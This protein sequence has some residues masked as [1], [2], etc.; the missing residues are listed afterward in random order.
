MSEFAETFIAWYISVN[1]TQKYRIMSEATI[2]YHLGWIT[3]FSDF[4]RWRHGFPMPDA[5][6]NTDLM[7]GKHK[8]ETARLIRKCPCQ[9]PANHS[10]TSGLTL[11]QQLT[12]VCY[13]DLYVNFIWWNILAFCL[14]KVRAFFVYTVIVIFSIVHS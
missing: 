10:C 12:M 3:F 8:W 7:E 2:T 13:T 9:W 1:L 6:S 4:Q 5:K 11:L 14:L